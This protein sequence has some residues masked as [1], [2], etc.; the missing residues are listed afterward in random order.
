VTFTLQPDGSTAVDQ[1]DEELDVGE[2]LLA[3]DQPPFR[4]FDGER[5]Y[6]QV[7]N[8]AATYLMTGTDESRG[9]RHFVRES[10][11]LEPVA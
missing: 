8:G 10:G 11:Q 1:W 6:F 2:E 7:G 3:Q 9:A 5:L 4:R